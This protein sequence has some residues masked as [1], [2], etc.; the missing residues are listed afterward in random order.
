MN[1]SQILTKETI[2]NSK[3]LGNQQLLNLVN[4]NYTHKNLLFI[5]E[6]L[7]Y[8]PHNFDDSWVVNLLSNPYEDLR[9]WAVKTLGKT[10]KS[11]NLEVLKK[12]AHDDESTK[13]RREAISS[14]GRLKVTAIIKPLLEFLNDEDPKIILQAIRGLLT[15]KGESEVDYQL[16]K[17]IN[18]PNEIIKKVIKKTYF[19]QTKVDINHQP[20]SESYPFLKNVIVLGDVRDT[21]KFIPDE[22]F[23]LTFTSPPYYNA[24]DYSIYPSYQAYLEFLEEVFQLTYEKTKEGR[25]LIV[26]TSPIIIARISRQHSSK[27]YPIPFDIHNFLIKIGWEFID[28]IIWQKPEASVKNRNAGFLQHRKPLAYKPNVVTEYLMVYRKQSD[29]LIDWNIRQYDQQI[30][31]ESKIKDDYETSN[32]WQIDP[33]YDKVHSAVFPL[34]L[35]QRVIKYYSFKGDLIFDPFAGSGTLGR[36]ADSLDRYFFLTEKEP[37]YFDYIQSLLV[38]PL[39]LYPQR[40][41]KFFIFE[42]FKKNNQ[43]IRFY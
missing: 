20:H 42:N 15:F 32:V 9:F 43:I 14:M 25:F 8:L 3:N 23:H 16:Q 2:E 36:A 41:P 27:R 10:K 11:Q 24:R 22:S 1:N 28:D 13:V 38:K 35:C 4:H 6:N 40:Q 30:V 26:N 21:L 34:E 39:N 19:N 29:K 12:I 33:K 7:G 17:L 18:H 37:K 31:E 5:L